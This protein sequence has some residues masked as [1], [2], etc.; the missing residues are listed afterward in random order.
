MDQPTNEYYM[1]REFLQNQIAA[2]TESIEKKDALIIS[3]QDRSSEQSQNLYKAHNATQSMRDA[4]HEWTM[5]EL[6]NNGITEDQAEAIA[7]ICDF[8]LSKEVE[9]EVTV[10]YNFTVQCAH[11]E[12]AEDIIN[13][14]DFDAITYDMDK[15]TWV[16]SSIDRIDI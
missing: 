12:D 7:E 13:D 15:I 2:L 4:M 9:V 3:M 1:T 11:D 14:V 5:T 8:E 16:S 10:T 6:A